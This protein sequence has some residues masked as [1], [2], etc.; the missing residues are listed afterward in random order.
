MFTTLSCRSKTAPRRLEA[1]AVI[2]LGMGSENELFLVLHI[3]TTKG[4]AFAMNMKP[5]NFRYAF[6]AV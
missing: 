5:N 2:K 3:I 6:I 1:T 4:M